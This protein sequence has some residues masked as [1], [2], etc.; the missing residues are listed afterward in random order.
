MTQSFN[1]NRTHELLEKIHNE[2]NHNDIVNAYST[3]GLNMYL[4]EQPPISC[5]N[6]RNGWLYKKISALDKINWF[7]YGDGN[8]YTTIGDVK[9]LNSLITIDVY[10]GNNSIPYFKVYSKPT[11]INDFSW[12]KSAITYTLKV[13]EKIHL[14]EEIQVWSGVKP[15]KQSNR[16][17]V[18][19]VVYNV[20]TLGTDT[21]I[22]ELLSISIHTSTDSPIGTKILVS[23]VGYDLYDGDEKVVRRIDLNI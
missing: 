19:F 2:E 15:K 16:R 9:S 23:Q 13:G 20:D 4:T 17:M 5:D 1:S 6:G 8:S 21:S 3:E 18:E 22:E 11:G 7:Y 12:Y 10:V 14:G